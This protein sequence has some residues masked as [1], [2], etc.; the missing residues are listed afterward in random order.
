MI[1]RWSNEGQVSLEHQL[2]AHSQSLKTVSFMTFGDLPSPSSSP[3]S[4]I[5][6]LPRRTLAETCA[7]STLSDGR[8]A[9][10]TPVVF[11]LATAAFLDASRDSSALSFVGFLSNKLCPTPELAIFPPSDVGLLRFRTMAAIGAQD[12]VYRSQGLSEEHNEQ[13]GGDLFDKLLGYDASLRKVTVA[14]HHS[15][16]Q[17][18]PAKALR[19]SVAAKFL[20]TL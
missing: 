6:R 2:H 7:S 3:L 9:E 17:Y 5:S 4:S 8:E 15:T 10:L 20:L 12:E 11:F 16:V 19:A 18:C 13:G 1:S 14:S